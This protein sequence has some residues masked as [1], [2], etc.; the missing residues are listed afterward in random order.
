MSLILKEIKEEHPQERHDHH[1]W[2]KNLTI[3]KAYD[4]PKPYALEMLF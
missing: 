4:N 1:F 3:L 2:R